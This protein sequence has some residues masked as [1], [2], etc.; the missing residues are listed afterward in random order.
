MP[1][2]REQQDSKSTQSGEATERE[3]L[4]GLGQV[5]GNSRCCISEIAGNLRKNFWNEYIIRADG[6]RITTWINGVMGVDY[7]EADPKIPQEGLIGIQVHGGG[8]A[9]IEAK[10]IMIE[11]RPKPQRI[12]NCAEAM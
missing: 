11:E 10:D 6:P 9:L 2:H 8:K 5:A 3:I 12:R 1:W 7:L 4:H